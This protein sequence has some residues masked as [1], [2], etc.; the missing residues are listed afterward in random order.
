MGGQKGSVV[1]SNPLKSGSLLG[2]KGS[3]NKLYT[4]R[5][6]G[7]TSLVSWTKN[8]Q[9]G[10]LFKIIFASVACEIVAVIL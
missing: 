10:N 2:T 6:N 3:V 4:N 8:E 1:L 7:A 5:N 9:N